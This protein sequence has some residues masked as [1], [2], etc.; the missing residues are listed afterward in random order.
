MMKV[1]KATDEAV[2]AIRKMNSI[3]RS[4]VS[5]STKKQSSFFSE[6]SAKYSGPFMV[7]WRNSSLLY[8]ESPPEYFGGNGNFAGSILAPDMQ[9]LAHIPR[10]GA[11]FIDGQENTLL[12]LKVTWDEN[13]GYS[14]YNFDFVPDP[15]KTCTDETKSA[16]VDFLNPKSERYP[17]R[18]PFI[19]IYPLARIEGRKITQI[20]QGHIVDY[21]RWWRY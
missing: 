16:A 7:T 8:I 6:S 15:W 3:R 12:V 19:S 18:D 9:V 4:L 11:S 1:I 5:S 21:G 14:G 10:N 2:N 13:S 17:Y 20:Q